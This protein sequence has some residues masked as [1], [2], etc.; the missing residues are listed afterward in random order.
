MNHLSSSGVPG[1]PGFRNF[2]A[3][4]AQYPA[5]LLL[6]ALPL[7]TCSGDVAGPLVPSSLS[8]AGGN[9]QTAAAGTALP[10]SVV[11]LV[12]D[13]EG[14]PVPQVAVS[15]SVTGGGGS[16]SPSTGTTDAVGRVSARWTLGTGAG[17]NSLDARV[18]D[19]AP[20]TFTA[21]A[22]AGAP[23]RVAS[24]SGSGQ[25]GVVGEAL[26]E[27]VVVRVE[28]AHGNPVSD[29]TVTWSVVSGDGEVSPVNVSADG[30][31]EA[32]AVWTLGT[33]VGANELRASAEPMGAAML[34][35]TGLAGP[36]AR[37][38]ILPADTTLPGGA[39]HRFVPA[40]E[41]E[42]GNA[43]EGVTVAWSSSDE[44]V[45]TVEAD[46]VVTSRSEGAAEI[47]ASTGGVEAVAALTVGVPDP[48]VVERHDVMLRATVESEAAVEAYGGVPP[49]EWSVPEGEM[50][51]GLSLSPAGEIAGAATAEGS[52]AVTVRVTDARGSQALGDL[53]IRVCEAPL[54]LG[55]GEAVVWSFPN[56]CG[57]VLAEGSYAVYRI[58]VTAA[59][60]QSTGSV[61]DPVLGGLL[62]E[63][64]VTGKATGG[65]VPG[66][67]GAAATRESRTELERYAH[68]PDDAFDEG[69][70]ALMRGTEALHMELREEELHRF[71]GAPAQA[72]GPR[73]AG[74]EWQALA[75]EPAENRTFFA[76]NP[77]GS[78][79]IEIPSTL[80]ATS[81]NI[82]YYQDDSVVGTEDLA[83]D[84]EVQ[85]VLDYYDSYGKPIIDEVFGGLGPEGT[86]NNFSGGER[87]AA[88][89]D[90]N[91]KFI[92][93]QLSSAH[94]RSSAAAY[95]SGCDRYPRQENYNAGGYYCTGSNEAEITYVRRPS[96][97]FYLGSIVHEAKHISS[98]GYAVLAGRGYNPSW[99][100]EG[101]AEIAKELSSRL[102][103]GFDYRQELSFSDLYPGG[104]VPTRATYGM[105]TVQSRARSFL[106]AAPGN[107]LIG[108]PNPNSN[109]STYYGSSWLFHRYLADAYA[110]V[111]VAEFFRGMNTGSNE[112]EGIEQ[113]TSRGFSELVGEFM[114]A[115]GV[116]GMTSARA[117]AT[118]RFSS[119]D[120]AGIAERFAGGPWPYI[121]G[122][123]TFA[124]ESTVFST[125]Y[126]ATNFFDLSS[127]DGL[128]QRVDLLGG[129][130]AVPLPTWVEGTLTITRV[131]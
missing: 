59:S 25:E 119:Y 37:L 10:D 110:G 43:V 115:V 15:W 114:L 13:V 61:V 70:R 22:V 12:A 108:N 41:D 42:Y 94:I 32:R 31:G 121:Q 34:S 40:A 88:D 21:S 87:L 92:I 101:T 120:F 97:D 127:V 4:L 74:L 38:G 78:G 19:L 56:D 118:H 23:A 62:L 85:A 131:R 57:V 80:R 83:T 27:A 49:F 69:I 53:S 47:R 72:L 96:S 9:E 44:A 5:T 71:A 113:A 104:Q 102:A 1:V 98:H 65:I 126:T 103:A 24:V 90:G 107:G 112:T 93:L 100:E 105:A 91:G 75:A 109:N 2:Q 116:E 26:T 8:A 35:A 50:P 125:Y 67:L 63:R 29:A 81:D 130:A 123:A 84:A 111:E 82:I 54:A 17:E 68:G 117:A 55:V 60:Y 48:L 6:V 14:R 95:V 77:E 58:G 3:L 122:S 51:P 52:Y 46:G 28:D 79:R 64:V 73:R 129:E 106:R 20:L 66:A 11:V 124:D 89:L 7:A 18:A 33:T 128:S 16:I 76:T 30:N 86:T 99:I 39:S 36:P 45:A